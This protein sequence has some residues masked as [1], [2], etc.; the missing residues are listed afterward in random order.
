[1]TRLPRE[2]DY[3]TGRNSTYP[4]GK[5]FIY[6]SQYCSAFSSAQF[7]C[8]DATQTER[9]STVSSLERSRC[10]SRLTVA[11]H[12]RQSLKASKQ[13][14]VPGMFQDG[15]YS[16]NTAF[17]NAVDP[18]TGRCSLPDASRGFE[19]VRMTLSCRAL[20]CD[21][22]RSSRIIDNFLNSRIIDATTHEDPYRPA[23]APTPQHARAFSSERISCTAHTRTALHN[24]SS[25]GRKS[26]NNCIIR[27]PGG[28]RRVRSRGATREPQCVRAHWMAISAIVITFGRRQQFH[29]DDLRA[30]RSKRSA[31]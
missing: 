21:V 16:L 20:S 10:E 3:R 8:T 13:N 11:A 25:A 29:G 6:L 28:A 17:T 12:S 4:S 5:F 7:T 15:F 24:F 27:V 18:S 1:L 14:F 9:K 2:F 30:S 22:V 19:Y 23:R 31:Q 26:Q